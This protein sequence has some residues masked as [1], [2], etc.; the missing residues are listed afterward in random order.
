MS[1][2]MGCVLQSPEIIEKSRQT[3][4][5]KPPTICPHCDKSCKGGNVTR[6]HFDTCKLKPI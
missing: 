2:K 5:N 3:K 6:H 4:E 1:R